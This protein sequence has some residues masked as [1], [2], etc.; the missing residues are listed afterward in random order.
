MALCNVRPIPLSFQSWMTVVFAIHKMVGYRY[1]GDS[2]PWVTIFSLFNPFTR[3]LI[4]L[5]RF[6]STFYNA[7]FS[8]A[9]TSAECVILNVKHIS[10]TVVA[11]STCY[12]GANEWKTVNYQYRSVFVVS[13]WDKL[14][15][16]NELFYCLNV[17]GWLGLYDLNVLGGF[18]KYLHPNA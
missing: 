11:I 16:A 3:E 7:A 17:T 5:P 15:F 18:W 9:P 14:V 12:P 1:V 8:C 2:G 13:I 6:E 4:K 10:S